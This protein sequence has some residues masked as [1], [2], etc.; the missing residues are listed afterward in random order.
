[1]NTRKIPVTTR[2]SAAFTLTELLTVIAII[3]V[4]ATIIIPVV[5][6]VRQTSRQSVCASNLRQVGIAMNSYL[7]DHR[8]A[9]PGYEKIKDKDGEFYALVRDVGVRWQLDN[10]KPTRAII[11]HLAPYMDIQMKIPATGSVTGISKFAV[12]PS[13]PS[14][15]D[16]EPASSYYLSNNVRLNDGTLKRPFAFNGKQSIKRLDMA[17]PSRA[18]AMFDID[19]PILSLISEG[20]VT[21]A[22]ETAVHGS[23]RNVLYFDGH[24][25]SV[26]ADINPMEKL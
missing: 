15:G 5:G 8:E 22:P 20:K 11:S 19:A 10:G 7:A 23:T 9:L 12:C 14:A 17:N 2:A 26:V 4:L 16:A 24:V 13:I 6:K 1:M 18:V 3:G 21:T 25:A